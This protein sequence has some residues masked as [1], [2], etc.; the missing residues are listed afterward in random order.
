MD[1]IV[2]L[3]CELRTTQHEINI[4]YLLLFKLRCGWKHIPFREKICTST[5]DFNHVVLRNDMWIETKK[6]LHLISN[7]ESNISWKWFF[8]GMKF[9][10]IFRF[11]LVWRWLA[12]NFKAMKSWLAFYSNC[13]QKDS[14]HLE[15]RISY[16]L[17]RNWFKETKY[18]VFP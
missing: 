17:T 6:H 3:P 9:V 12:A 13:F 5:N 15:V 8:W 14:R 10:V 7:I 1:W 4:K 16:S 11:Y 2:N 18:Q